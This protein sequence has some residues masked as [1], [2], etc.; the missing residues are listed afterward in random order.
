MLTGE[1]DS[2]EPVVTLS[3]INEDSQLELWFKFVSISGDTLWILYDNDAGTLKR[4]ATPN[5]FEVL[6]RRAEEQRKREYNMR[7]NV[8][9][10]MRKL[11]RQLKLPDD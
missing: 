3:L 8:R 1:F 9:E 11:T 4:E 5:E 10:N 2:T 7:A 6:T